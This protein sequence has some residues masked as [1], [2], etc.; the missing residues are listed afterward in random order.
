MYKRQC[1]NGLNLVGAYIHNINIQVGT[2][3]CLIPVCL[4][5]TSNARSGKHGHKDII[6]IE[7]MID[8]DLDVLGYLDPDITIDIIRDG[9]IVEKKKGCV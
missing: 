1:L 4:F 8:L 2:V 9:K 7:S 5:Y 6:K 3:L